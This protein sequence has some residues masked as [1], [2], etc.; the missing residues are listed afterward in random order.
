MNENGGDGIDNNEAKHNLKLNSIVIGIGIPN[1]NIENCLILL[2]KLEAILTPHTI[3]ANIKPL[4]SE[5]CNF[6][7]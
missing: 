6:I 3:S 7:I 1:E 4:S 5:Q 2:H